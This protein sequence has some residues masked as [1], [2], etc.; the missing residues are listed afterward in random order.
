MSILDRW[1]GSAQRTYAALPYEEL[2]VAAGE[3]LRLKT[4]AHCAAW[5]LHEAHD[6]S[7]DQDE[8]QLV[9]VLEDGLIASAPAQI[10]GT[11]D[12]RD[13]TWMWAWNN[14]SIAESMRRDA[15]RVRAYG[16]QI[17]EEKLTATKWVGEEN[18]AWAMT[19]LACKLC[20]AQGAYRGPAGSTLVFITFGDVELR[21][22]FVREL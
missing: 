17:G 16:E 20:A 8:G 22:P 21:K 11:F 5:R 12:T 4:Q 10:I 15:A 14:P 19:A 18:D 7:L 3:E 6:W 2:L 1:F 13:N 9:I